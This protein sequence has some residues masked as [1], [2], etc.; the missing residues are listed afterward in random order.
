MQTSSPVPSIQ[1]AIID[2]HTLF[3]QGMI[4]LL[5]DFKEI[6]ILFDAENGED[7]ISKL[8]KFPLPEIVLMDI[9]MPV[10]DGYKATAWLKEN[11]PAVK[12]LALSMSDED[13][14][15]INMLKSGAVGYML[16]ESKIRDVV[17]AMQNIQKHGYYLNELVSGKLL[18]TM[19]NKNT[20]ADKS[21]ELTSNELIFLKLSCSELT[22]RQIADEMNLSPH[23][24][25]NYRESLFQKFGLK[26]RTGMVL[27]AIKNQIITV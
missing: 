10:M 18:Y 26:S 6:N 2:N 12:V 16:K 14:P 21:K 24:I 9:T 25:D 3:R 11:H 15:I 22:Y 27:F 4:S 13:K 19:Q 20:S 1:I 17:Y 5:D 8:K 7:M 23:T